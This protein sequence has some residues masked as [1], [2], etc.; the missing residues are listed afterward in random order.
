MESKCNLCKSSR[1]V[2]VGAGLGRPLLH[3]L[4]SPGIDSAH[5]IELDS[6]KC[7]KAEAFMKQ[8]AAAL[9]KKGFLKSLRIP[10]MEC[11]PIEEVASLDATHAYSFWE[12]VPYDAR[13]AFGRL[14]HASSQCQSV[15]VVQRS[16]RHADPAVIMEEDYE[17]GPLQLVSTLPVSMSGSG[18]SFT[19]YVFNKL[20]G[21]STSQ[22]SVQSICTP[23]IAPDSP[24]EQSLSASLTECHHTEDEITT[25]QQLHLKTPNKVRGVVKPQSGSVLR[26]ARRTKFHGGRDCKGT[27]TED[28]PKGARRGLLAPITSV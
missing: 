23:A 13:V 22:D 3:A 5:G 24:A 7:A 20:G 12:G 2:D 14:F 18:R 16:M 27:S 9:V 26:S 6:I 17:F 1:L 10:S 4:L 21:I 15:A 25:P 11:S 19:C 8:S 28:G